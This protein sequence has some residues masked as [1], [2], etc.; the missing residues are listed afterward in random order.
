MLKALEKEGLIT[1][2]NH[3]LDKRNKLIFLTKEGANLQSFIERSGNTIEKVLMVDI[4]AK[5]VTQAKEVLKDFY[6][7]LSSTSSIQNQNHE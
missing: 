6:L 7:L 3:P 5:N 1:K 2:K 4:P